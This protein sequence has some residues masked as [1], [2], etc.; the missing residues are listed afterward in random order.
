MTLIIKKLKVGPKPGDWV[1]SQSGKDSGNVG[2]YIETQLKEA[3]LYVSSVGV[4]IPLLGLEV[5]TRN[6]RAVSPFTICRMSYDE[7]INTDYYNSKVYNSIKNLYL[8]RYDNSKNVITSVEV[9]NWGYDPVINNFFSLSYDY[10]R[11]MLQLNKVNKTTINNKSSIGYFE[12]EK[13]G[14]YEF[15]LSKDELTNLE[16]SK[17]VKFSTVFDKP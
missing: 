5:K 3:G 2:R 10:G 16:Q 9:H 11:K 15:R 13:S 7:I 8:V 6:N 4:D 1:P 17:Y 12:K 14:L